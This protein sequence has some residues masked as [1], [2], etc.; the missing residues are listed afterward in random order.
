ML[1]TKRFLHR[2]KGLRPST[3]LGAQTPQLRLGNM[4]FIL[5]SLLFGASQTYVARRAYS[6]AQRA[7][8]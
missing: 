7:V 6:E 5:S 1:D 2:P 4:F 8:L 3:S